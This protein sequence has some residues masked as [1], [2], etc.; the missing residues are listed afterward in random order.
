MDRTKSSLVARVDSII[1]DFTRQ[2]EIKSIIQCK[3][4]SYLFEL[5]WQVVTAAI[6]L[7][8]KQLSPVEVKSFA[9]GKIADGANKLAVVTETTKWQFG[10]AIP[11]ARMGPNYYLGH[12][13][14]HTQTLAEWGSFMEP[15]KYGPQQGSADFLKL[16][17]SYTPGGFCGDL[18]GIAGTGADNLWRMAE[19]RS[20]VVEIFDT[21]AKVVT[22]FHQCLNGQSNC[23]RMRISSWMANNDW[24]KTVDQL[25]HADPATQA[26]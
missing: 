23:Q 6:D 16:H 11:P 20:H 12:L 7:G 24:E 4:R 9:V 2:D 8:L 13:K 14:H 21:Y 5:M 15:L 10:N 25:D 22:S 19:M 3:I 17:T 1:L 18:D 26:S